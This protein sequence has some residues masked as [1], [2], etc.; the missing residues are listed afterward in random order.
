MFLSTL[1]IST[2]K[3]KNCGR[4][5]ALILLLAI[6]NFRYKFKIGTIEEIFSNPVEKKRQLVSFDASNFNYENQKLRQV[7]G[8]HFV[9]GD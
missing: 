3:I 4:L 8:S 5:A 7:S 2:T 9:I 6:K 1:Q